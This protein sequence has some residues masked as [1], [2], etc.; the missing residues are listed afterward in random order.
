MSPIGAAEIALKTH[1]LMSAGYPEFKE[2]AA[3][4]YKTQSLVNLTEAPED[5][6][7]SLVVDLMRLCQREGIDWNEDVS[8]RAKRLAEVSNTSPA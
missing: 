1:V 4:I 5:A 7:C 3:T 2:A 8:S 6:V